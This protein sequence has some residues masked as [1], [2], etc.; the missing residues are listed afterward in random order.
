MQAL[1]IVDMQR[2]MFREPDRAAQLPALLPVI[3]RLA[4]DYVAADLPVFDIRVVHKADRST[5]SR[6]ML[7]YDVACLIAGTEDIAFV[8]GLVMPSTA[9]F[10]AKTANSAF[11]G[12]EFEQQLQALGVGTLVLAG[13]FIDGCVG[14]TA[15]DAAQRGLDVVLAD[16]AMACC[17]HRH[18]VMMVEWLTAMYEIRTIAAAS[19]P[20]AS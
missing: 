2:W 17:D 8:E 10:I 7:K 13:A 5:W 3:N 18:R 4:A 20:A 16:D 11:L 14:L 12:T 15:A 6:L 1:A 9:R 19:L